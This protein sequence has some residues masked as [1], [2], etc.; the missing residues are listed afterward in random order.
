MSTLN[1]S[2]ELLKLVIQDLASANGLLNVGS[3][4]DNIQQI[5]FESLKF[6]ETSEAA[7]FRALNLT[8][9]LTTVVSSQPGKT[10]Y[11]NLSLWS[12]RSVAA[13]QLMRPLVTASVNS[14]PDYELVSCIAGASDEQTDL[15]NKLNMGVIDTLMVRLTEATEVRFGIDRICSPWSFGNEKFE[16]TKVRKLYLPV[17]SL[18]HM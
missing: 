5:E 17:V 18:P 7:R 2:R 4:A 10:A 9:K 16:I 13:E 1:S 12:S 15:L 14:W 3:A 6:E 8:E 11:K